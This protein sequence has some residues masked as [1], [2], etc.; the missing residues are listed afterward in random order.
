MRMI[1]LDQGTVQ[2]IGEHRVA[3]LAT[4]DSSGKP[5]VIPICFVFAGGAFYTALDEKPKQVE[6][7]KMRRV[8]NIKANPQVSLVIDDYVEDWSR[9]TYALIDGRAEIVEPGC[10]EHG[11]A[12]VLLRDKYLQ[13]VSMALEARPV[14]KIIP[15]RVKRWPS[16]PE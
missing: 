16:N 12:V 9:L 2:F 4:A 8:R 5:L 1:D 14:I 6:L 7:S 15:E 13:Y 3:R 11:R 10:E